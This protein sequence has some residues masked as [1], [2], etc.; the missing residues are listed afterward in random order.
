MKKQIT[1]ILGLIVLS[2]TSFGQNVDSLVAK[3]ITATG[4]MELY[5]GIEKYAVHQLGTESNVPYEATLAVAFNEKKVLKTRTVLSRN[6]LYNLDGTDATLYIP[7]GGLNRGSTYQSQKL[8]DFEKSKLSLEL[9]DKFLPILNYKSKGYKARMIG[10]KVIN[11][12]SLIQVEF[13]KDDIVRNYF[14]NGKT[15]LIDQE[16]ITYSNG[17]KVIY[18]HSVYVKLKNGLSYPSESIMTELGKTRKIKSEL[19][20]NDVPESEYTV[21]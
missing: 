5:Q 6:F 7:T 11:G 15:G 21:K 10:N 3:Y 2:L 14:F 13:S 20:I 1:Y 4:G 18:Q 19:V 8:S 12:V 17:E 16:D 9:V